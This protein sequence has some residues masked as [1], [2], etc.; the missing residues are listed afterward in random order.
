MVIIIL[1]M[2]TYLAQFLAHSKCTTAIDYHYYSTVLNTGPQLLIQNSRGQI[3]SGIQ[4]F[5]NF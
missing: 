4:N 1:K 2:N 3:H 5:S